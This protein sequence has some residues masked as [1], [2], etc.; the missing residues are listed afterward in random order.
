MFSP[1]ILLTCLIVEMYSLTPELEE[2]LLLWKL[3]ETEFE[4][5]PLKNIHNNNF[6]F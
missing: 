1:N 3:V 6:F 5:M 4:V 2:I